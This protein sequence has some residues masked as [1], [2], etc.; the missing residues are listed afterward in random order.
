M[1]RRSGHDDSSSYAAKGSDASE[2]ST[3]QPKE[4]HSDVRPAVYAV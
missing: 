3:L 1:E 4:A 2:G